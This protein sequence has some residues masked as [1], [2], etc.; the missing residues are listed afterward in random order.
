MCE[1]NFV[2]YK[3]ICLLVFL[4]IIEWK[5][6]NGEFENLVEVEGYVKRMI[7]NVK[8]FYFKN[9][10]IFD[11]VECVCKVLSNFMMKRNFVY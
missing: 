3:V 9:F 11:D 4:S 10:I 8:E 5:L 7:F 6:D 1:G 2:Y